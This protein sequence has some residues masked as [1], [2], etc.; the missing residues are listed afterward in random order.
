M[1]ARAFGAGPMTHYRD[2]RWSWLDAAV[3]LAAVVVL[4]G[5][6]VLGGAL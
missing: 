5:A 6:L 2:L 4:V 3:A 1:D